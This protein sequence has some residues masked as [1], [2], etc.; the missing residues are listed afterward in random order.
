MSA[1]P[2]LA[3]GQRFLQQNLPP[4]RVLVC[5]VTGSH[6]YGFASPDSDLDLK[7]IHL[8]P[9]E[10]LLGLAP[11]EESHDRLSFL[12][13]VECDLTTNE[14]K[15]A[16]SLLLKGNG[17]I[18]ERL[19]SPYQLCDT[20][21]L[22]ELKTLAKNALSLKF[23]GHYA[24][25]FQGVCREHEK[26]PAPAAKS[27]LYSYRVALTGAHLLQTGEL[28]VDL[29]VLAPL[30]NFPEAEALM[31]RK[32]ESKEKALLT[33]EEDAHYRSFWPRLVSLLESARDKSQLPQ[34]PKNR[35]E[36]SDWLVK[37]RCRELGPQR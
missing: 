9:T 8:A 2:N 34:E 36:V 32:R 33:K 4:G 1:I 12:D 28:E 26:A 6:I 17:N 20:K 7:G 15:Q 30:Y 23:F 13:G 14:A 18:L 10:S 16:L 29:R 35:K 5:A 22:S 24:G 25:F 27:L 11:P 19:F 21:E 37:L 31:Q 3:V